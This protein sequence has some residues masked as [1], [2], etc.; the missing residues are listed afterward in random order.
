MKQDTRDA[1]T[2]RSSWKGRLFMDKLYDDFARKLVKF[3]N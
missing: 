2:R 1:N 3:S